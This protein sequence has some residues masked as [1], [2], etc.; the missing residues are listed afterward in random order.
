MEGRSVWG[1]LAPLASRGLA[2]GDIDLDG[3][4]DV[5]VSNNNGPARLYL[6]QTGGS[7][8]IRIRLESTAANTQGLGA[9]VGLH[10]SDGTSA[11]RRLHSDGSYFSASEAAAH[12]A[13]R[14]GAEVRSVEVRWPNG[15]AEMFPAV[16]AGRTATLVRG[17][18]SANL[19]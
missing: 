19:D 12:F 17:E 13:L 9:R 5:V 16:A 10:L 6:N 7:R 2:T 18:G 3:D 15:G 14:E 11:W 1:R 4:L 8:S